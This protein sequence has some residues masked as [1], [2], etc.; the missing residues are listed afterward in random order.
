MTVGVTLQRTVTPSMRCG[1]KRGAE[2][3]CRYAPLYIFHRSYVGAALSL[4]MMQNEVLMGQSQGRK[5]ISPT[6]ESRRRSS[7]GIAKSS[8]RRSSVGEQTWA[9]L[10][11]SNSGPRRRSNMGWSIVLPASGLARPSGT[12]GAAERR[13][14]ADR[15]G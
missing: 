13:S 3:R 12:S 9:C 4:K 2:P 11:G 10:K 5:K 15:T 7:V 1:V 14:E 8:H 6:T